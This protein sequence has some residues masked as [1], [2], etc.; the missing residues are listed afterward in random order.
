MRYKFGILMLLS[1]LLLAACGDSTP[2]EAFPTP[3]PNTKAD[4]IVST[5]PP[6][7]I[8]NAKLNF[9]QDEAPHN[10][11]TEWWYYT[12]HIT[13]V[14]G[15]E[16]GFEYVIFQGIRAD[17]PPGYVSHFA[18]TDLNKKSFKYDQRLNIPA[19]KTVF[20]GDKGF[21][22]ALNDWTIQGYDGTDKLKATMN[23]KSYSF[24]VTLKDLKGIVLH[25][26]GLF[27]YGA[28]GFSYYYSRPR[29]SVEGTFSADGQTEQIKDGVAWFDHQWGDFI[30]I[31]GGW[32]WFSV[33]LDDKSEVMVYYLRD[34][35]N[36][37]VDVFGSYSPA[38]VGTCTPSSK[39]IQSVDLRQ[40]NFKIEPTA[41]WKSP[42]TGGVYPS[43]WNIT[44]QAEK[45]PLLQ[46]HIKP[47]LQDQELNTR[48]TTGVIYWE[49]ACEVSGTKDGQPISGKSYV[50]LTGYARSQAN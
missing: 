46:L 1:S 40:A 17:F 28:G 14:S 48:P 41:Q 20:G 4:Q 25:G 23:D 7:P 35:K 21:D 45:V 3:V 30:P 13:T 16:Y 5:F 2:P 8:P 31:A 37:V 43:G 36:N 34:D 39:P 32:D 29:M 33:H 26:G 49:G 38:C 12:G 50:E 10:N 24:D 11:I 18:I 47:S 6:G 27:S 9:P 15:K 19:R 42:S 22:L 44:I